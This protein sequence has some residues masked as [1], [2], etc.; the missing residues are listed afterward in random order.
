MRERTRRR[1]RWFVRSVAKLFLSLQ[2]YRNI[3][4]R[5]AREGNTFVRYLNAVNPSIGWINSSDIKRHIRVL[6]E[7]ELA[8]LVRQEPSTAGLAARLEATAKNG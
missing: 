2:T 7:S 1:S 3:G 5:M 4:R 8:V 6:L